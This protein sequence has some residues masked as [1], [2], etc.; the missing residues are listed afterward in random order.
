MTPLISCAD[1]S[2]WIPTSSLSTSTARSTVS[3]TRGSTSRADARPRPKVSWRISA[4][5]DPD[6]AEA[7][8]KDGDPAET[9]EFLVTDAEH[10]RALNAGVIDEVDGQDLSRALVER[11]E[12]II[13]GR[14]AKRAAEGSG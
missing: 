6:T 12:E 8:K 5:Y 10:H 13:R 3:A 9:T 2:A 1:S 14:A 7:I 11:V 4:G